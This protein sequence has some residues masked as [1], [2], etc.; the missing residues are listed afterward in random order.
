MDALSTDGKFTC[1]GSASFDVIT[2]VA[3]P[4]H[5]ALHCQSACTFL[6]CD[7]QTSECERIDLP[8]GTSC[9]NDAGSC[10]GGSCETLNI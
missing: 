3:T 2:G 4:V 9:A 8:D 1:S 10:I 5:V 7:D 6:F